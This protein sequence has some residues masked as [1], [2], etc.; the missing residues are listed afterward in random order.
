VLT[1]PTLAELENCIG[2]SF[3]WKN[4]R[5]NVVEIIDQPL[6]LVAQKHTTEQV[7]QNDVYGRARREV[8]TTISIPVFNIDGNQL[9]PEFSLIQF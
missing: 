4:E 3:L 5:Y 9:H 2:L 7:M 1:S 6:T 8:R